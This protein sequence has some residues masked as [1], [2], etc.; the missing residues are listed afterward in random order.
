MSGYLTEDWRKKMNRSLDSWKNQSGDK[1]LS[2][3]TSGSRGWANYYADT[4]AIFLRVGNLSHNTIEID[5]QEI[6]YVNPPIGAEGMR[7]RLKVG[8][9]LISITAD[10][11]MVGCVREDIGEAYI[12]QHLCLARQTGEYC[13]SYLAYYL[14]SP[15]GSLKQ[16]TKIQRGVTKPGLTLSDIRSIVFSIPELDEQEEIVRH[17]D[18]LFAYADLVKINYQNALEKVEELKSLILDQAFRGELVSQ[19]ASDEPASL[20]LE[21][22]RTERFAQP[23]RPK[24]IS[25]RKSAMTKPSKESLKEI[26]QKLPKDQIFFDDFRDQFPDYELL[27]NILFDILDEAEPIIKQVF[28]QEKELMCFIR[29]QK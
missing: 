1:V 12:N 8:D 28:D 5:L 27:K 19:D 22:I 20:L 26:I 24:R 17:I 4:G 14:A 23:P 10:L 9:I 21:R 16:L 25:I 15:L 6:Q 3:V 13:S 7:T 29:E 18:R 11:G 2:L